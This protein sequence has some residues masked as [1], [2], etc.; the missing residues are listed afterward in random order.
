MNNHAGLK[1]AF[2]PNGI[3]I[4]G[5]SDEPTVHSYCFIRCLLDYGYSGSIY[6]ASPHRESVLG[7]Q[8]YPSLRSVPNQ[9]DYIICCIPSPFTPDLLDECY[10]RGT[11]FVQIFSARLIDQCSLPVAVKYPRYPTIAETAKIHLDIQRL[12]ETKGG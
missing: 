2:Q 7:M 3:A 5:A 9:V 11:K 8:A 12:H 4:I 1:A 10:D 6:P